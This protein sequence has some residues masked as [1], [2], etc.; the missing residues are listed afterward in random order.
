MA[1]ANTLCKK[2]LNVKTAVVEDQDF[3]QD[4]DGVS[5]L[6]IK[7]RPNRWHEHDCP[8]CHKRCQPYD[9]Q[10][11]HPRTWRALDWGGV[12]VEIAYSTHRILCP[13]HGVVVAD[14]PWAYPGIGFTKD[15]DLTV[16]W[17]AKYL[18]RS[19]VSAYMRIDWE[20]IG[21]CVHRALNDL[22]PERSRRL[23]GPKRTTRIRP[24]SVQPGRRQKRSRTLPILL[25]KRHKEH[26]LN[27]I[28]HG[29]SN[30]RIGATNNKIK[31][32]PNRK[33]KCVKSV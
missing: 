15:F 26:I 12:L 25:E 16:A 22:E 1:S 17:L 13:E 24:L 32:L 28:R 21:R 9:V 5:H 6:R 7:A 4:M 3:Y 11:K 20:T 2:I 27:T 8:F 30:A 33:P 10:T 14:V 18:P 31:P 29:I 19:A 23:D